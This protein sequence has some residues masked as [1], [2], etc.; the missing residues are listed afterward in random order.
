MNFFYQISYYKL[1]KCKFYYLIV[2]LSCF[3]IN[4]SSLSAQAPDITEIAP[5]EGGMG[6][7]IFVKGTGFGE[8]VEDISAT[9]QG[10]AQDVSLEALEVNEEG[11]TFRLPAIPDDMI[12]NLSSLTVELGNGQVV[13]IE[14]DFEDV[15]ADAAWVWTN[16]LIPLSDFIL[17]GL[18]V[19]AGN[20]PDVSSFHNEIIALG[21]L[22]LTI[23]Q[24]WNA[25]DRAYIYAR[26]YAE[27]NES[28][29]ISIKDAVFT[30]ESTLLE[31]ADRIRDLILKA[32]DESDTPLDIEC[33]VTGNNQ[34]ATITLSEANANLIASGNLAISVY[35]PRPGIGQI[36]TPTEG[37]VTEGDE[38]TITGE[39]FGQ[40]LDDL[41]IFFRHENGHLINVS[42]IEVN[43]NTIIG[44]LPDTINP[45]ADGQPYTLVVAIGQSS[46]NPNIQLDPEVADDVIIKE[47]WVLRGDPNRMGV[48]NANTT[49]SVPAK[50]N[51]VASFH[52]GWV[53]NN[54]VSVLID[55]EWGFG[56]EVCVDSRA[57][58][59]GFGIDSYYVSQFT[60]E[61]TPLECVTLIGELL[62]QT[63]ENHPTHPVEMD[64]EATET[65]DGILLTMGFSNGL[66]IRF[67]NINVTV[68]AASPCHY[69]VGDQSVDFCDESG[70]I[71]VPLNAV[72]TVP[73][74]VIGMNYCLSYNPTLMAPQ[75]NV[76]G[77]VLADLGTVVTAI[78]GSANA[79]YTTNIQ[80][81]TPDENHLHVAISYLSSAPPN[82]QFQGTGEVICVYFDI[83]EEATLGTYDLE[84]CELLE[85]YDISIE[86]E[87]AQV[88]TLNIEKSISEGKV[89]FWNDDGRI[90]DED[91]FLGFYGIHGANDEDCG[92][93]TNNYVTPDL[94]HF[95]Y[96]RDMGEHI[97]ITRNIEGRYGEDLTINPNMPSPMD[98]I[99]AEDARLVNL[100]TNFDPD[101]LPTPYQMIAADVNM[102]DGIFANDATLIQRRSILKIPE[103]PQVWNYSGTN[104]QNPPTEDSKDWRFIDLAST[105]NDD[106]TIH[107]DYPLGV[108]NPAPHPTSGY[109]RNDVPDVLTCLP[110][111]VC[112]SDIIDIYQS[113][114]VGDVDGNWNGLTAIALDENLKMQIELSQAQE[115]E[116][117]V[118]EIPITYTNEDGKQMHSFNMDIYYKSDRIELES[119]SATG[120]GSFVT[121]GGEEIEVPFSEVFEGI[122]YNA[123]IAGR[124]LVSAFTPGE[125]NPTESPIFLLRMRLKNPSESLQDI[126][127][128]VFSG[129]LAMVN[130]KRI[131]ASVN[132]EVITNI[133]P[134]ILENFTAQLYPN[135]ATGNV[136]FKHT[137]L[138]KAANITIYNLLGAA[139]QQTQVRSNETTHNIDLNNLS[140]GIYFVQLTQEGYPITT[141]KLIVK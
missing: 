121:P 14:P 116:P 30:Q 95:I 72:Q 103:F 24:N 5:A 22:S 10:L 71:C 51:I 132:D 42:P 9:L 135:P 83:D 7:V 108:G 12:G 118:F 101:F 85:S 41:C 21:E 54:D 92:N 43:D 66:P 34:E 123:D 102:D 3:F 111:P 100:I 86:P 8:D 98:Y 79:T 46:T 96:D 117:N 120:E 59:I 4:F 110:A 122:D 55:Q 32:I 25:G 82:A 39:N 93:K 56:M 74:G 44:K 81:I 19:T 75:T 45:S 61:G 104:A 29:N 58:G 130:G 13:E 133:D 124:L 89:I 127:S 90:L 64:I 49:I 73:D 99:N 26:I 136:L 16:D 113:V 107:P 17:D 28:I 115:V 106:F 76:I 23:D 1:P 105:N 141:I 70:A 35:P 48:A 6:D 15:Q 50:K 20:N 131:A 11:V 134:E 52:S 47:K 60:A 63:M 37:V 78:S 91:P 137:A 68:K 87:C 67:G 31:N 125:I 65:P 139:V 88:G 140:P 112:D 126:D 97:Q 138:D 57:H 2:F 33:T 53:W 69:E 62:E 18:E 40:N 36:T 27:N 114:L 109:W 84:V 119:I 38:I 80:S 77:K 94:G 129:T 128:K